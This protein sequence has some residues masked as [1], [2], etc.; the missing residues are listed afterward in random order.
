M[1]NLLVAEVKPENYYLAKLIL[2]ITFNL[3]F[4]IIGCVLYAQSFSNLIDA[5]KDETAEWSKGAIV[6]VTTVRANTT[7]TSCP[8]G[9][10]LEE[11]SFLGT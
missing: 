3:G 5:I 4:L 2:F 9:Y 11:G 7:N 6:D 8:I 10:E 1:R